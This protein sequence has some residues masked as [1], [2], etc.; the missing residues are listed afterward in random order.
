VARTRRTLSVKNPDTH[1]DYYHV[2][3]S[4]EEK[5]KS[6]LGLPLMKDHVLFGVLVVQTVREKLF[7]MNEIKMINNAGSRV[8]DIILATA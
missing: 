2:R 4:G 6:Y 1:P 7:F 3:G 5:Y 8:L